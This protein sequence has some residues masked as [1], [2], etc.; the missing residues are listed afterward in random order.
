[1]T[2]IQAFS[3]FTEVW[4]LIFGCFQPSDAFVGEEL[5]SKE[6]IHIVVK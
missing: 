5:L 4:Q 3:E 1:V 2:L 6:Y